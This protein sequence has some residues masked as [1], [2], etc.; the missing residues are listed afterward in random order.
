MINNVCTA[1]I[2]LIHKLHRYSVE[3]LMLKHY[4]LLIKNAAFPQL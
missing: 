1:I 2:F 4:S 3:V